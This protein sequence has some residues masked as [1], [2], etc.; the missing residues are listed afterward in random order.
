[1][2]PFS[3]VD[4]NTCILSFTLEGAALENIIKAQLEDTEWVVEVE[5]GLTSQEVISNIFNNIV[6]K[7][8]LW[9]LISDNCS[10]KKGRARYIVA[11]SLVSE[12]VST[13]FNDI[14]R[15]T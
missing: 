15:W 8:L 12:N 11:A 14:R 5:A 7:T 9:H 3:L 4:I 1:M 6:L 2:E 13:P 10:S